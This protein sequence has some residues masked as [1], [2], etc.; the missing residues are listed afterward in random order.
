MLKYV[1]IR[2]EV[3]VEYFYHSGTLFVN[4]S[5]SNQKILEIVEKFLDLKQD[6]C[7]N[8]NK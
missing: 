5:L 8:S 3:L 1:C 4:A 7:L 6:N 2:K